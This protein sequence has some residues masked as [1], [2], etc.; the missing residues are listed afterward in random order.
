MLSEKEIAVVERLQ[1]GERSGAP[2][3][4][5]LEQVLQLFAIAVKTKWSNKGLS[6]TSP[7]VMWDA[8]SK[9]Q[10]SNHTSQDTGLI[11]P[12]PCLRRQGQRHLRSLP[13]CK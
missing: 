10:V 12:R 3:K 6:S 2:A 7:R 5:S 13:E 9:Q 11:P 8:Y 4:F 1:D